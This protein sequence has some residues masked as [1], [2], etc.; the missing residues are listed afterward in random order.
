MNVC[1]WQ[2][3]RGRNSISADSTNRHLLPFSQPQSF[4]ENPRFVAAKQSCRIRRRRIFIQLQRR[5]KATTSSQLNLSEPFDWKWKC[6]YLE[7]SQ[8]TWSTS[9]HLK[10]HQ[11]TSKHL[12]LGGDNWC[13]FSCR[14][15]KMR[16][17]APN[18][19]CQTHLTANGIVST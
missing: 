14:D 10:V 17:L 5:W 8:S 9:E 11:S 12:E 6:K 7:V 3:V 4:K 15:G 1:F 19:M 18:Q 2:E 16:R 13:L